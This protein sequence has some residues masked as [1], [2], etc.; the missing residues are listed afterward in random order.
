MHSFKCGRGVHG[1]REGKTLFLVI[2]TD[3]NNLKLTES[4]KSMRL[5][6]ELS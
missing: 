2:R 3:L 5:L 6:G 1:I 4:G